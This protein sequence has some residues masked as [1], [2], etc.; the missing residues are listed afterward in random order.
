MLAGGA[1]PLKFL[2]AVR[3]SKPITVKIGHGAPELHKNKTKLVKVRDGI[4]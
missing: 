1:P 3:V 4:E 2:A